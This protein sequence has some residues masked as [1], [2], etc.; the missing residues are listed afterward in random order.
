M[1]WVL[2]R[3]GKTERERKRMGRG[4]E[5]E[6]AE[7]GDETWSKGR[8]RLKEESKG[9]RHYS[10]TKRTRREN[11]RNTE[12]LENREGERERRRRRGRRGHTKT[13]I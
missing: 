11:M 3:L 12:I 1:C 8:H 5:R 4:K 7:T 13:L 2:G 10:W 9:S 6:S